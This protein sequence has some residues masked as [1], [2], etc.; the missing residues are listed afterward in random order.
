MVWRKT[1]KVVFFSS[2]CSQCHLFV[3]REREE[4]N[5]MHVKWFSREKGQ[6]SWKLI[7]FFSFVFNPVMLLRLSQLVT[8]NLVSPLLPACLFFLARIP[9]HLTRGFVVRLLHFLPLLLSLPSSTF[10]CF[11]FLLFFFFPCCSSSVPLPPSLLFL[12]RWPTSGP[13]F[14]KSRPPK[15]KKRTPRRRSCAPFS[16]AC[17]L[18]WPSCA[19]WKMDSCIQT[20]E[21][22]WDLLSLSTFRRRKTEM[23]RILSWDPCIARARWQPSE[24][25]LAHSDMDAR[26]WRSVGRT[27]SSI[28][29]RKIRSDV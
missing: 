24:R 23:H 26:C 8:R 5:F 18:L 12:S 1:I 9:P 7:N 14:C 29:K 13:G 27:A 4:K 2:R 22:E 20:E 11:L 21:S 25:C 15:K 3:V 16:G 6:V 17:R 19:S 28:R 10:W